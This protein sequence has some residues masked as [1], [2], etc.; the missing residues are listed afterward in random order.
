MMS[1]IER[2]NDSCYCY[3]N[4]N[5][6]EKYEPKT[7]A[8]SQMLTYTGYTSTT[9]GLEH[10][11][12]NNI[13]ITKAEIKVKIYFPNMDHFDRTVEKRKPTAG[14]ETLK[15]ACEIKSPNRRIKATYK[16]RVYKGLVSAWEQGS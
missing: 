3:Q 14:C 6:V 5:R 9:L 13:S 15:A 2:R 4:G 12:Q 7:F 11:Y 10:C 1:H 16:L 8:N